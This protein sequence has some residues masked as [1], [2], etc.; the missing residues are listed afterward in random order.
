MNLI[1]VKPAPGRRVPDPATGHCLPP[2]GVRVA[3]SAYWSRRLADADIEIVAPAQPKP[4]T[5]RKGPTA[6]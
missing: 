4:K 1:H 2:K 6:Q 3:A 5:Q